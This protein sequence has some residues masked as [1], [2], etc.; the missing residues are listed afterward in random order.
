MWWGPWLFLGGLESNPGWQKV[1]GLFAAGG[2]RGCL[3]GSGL[4]L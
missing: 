3:L 4:V 2:E 1:L